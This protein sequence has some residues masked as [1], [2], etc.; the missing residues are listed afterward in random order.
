MN[1]EGERWSRVD[2]NDAK[3]MLNGMIR[4]ISDQVSVRKLQTFLIKEGLL[5]GEADGYIGPATRGALRKFRDKMNF[6][7]GNDDGRFDAVAY[8]DICL[9]E[10]FPIYGTLQ[11]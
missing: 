9:G 6:T 11:N 4:E 8:A 3:I 2:I 1:K 7:F 5:E 10:R